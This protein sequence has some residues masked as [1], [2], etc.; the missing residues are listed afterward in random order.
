MA[1]VSLAPHL[2]AL[3]E[4][5]RQP[6]AIL[7]PDIKSILTEYVK[8]GG[9]LAEALNALFSGYCGVPHMID[10]VGCILQELGINC[11]DKIYGEIHDRLVDEL[12]R[13]GLEKLDEFMN[14]PEPPS[15]IKA[16]LESDVWV[17]FLVTLPDEL[18]LH[19]SPFLWFCLNR[20]AKEKPRKIRNLPAGCIQYNAYLP[21]LTSLIEDLKDRKRSVNDFIK[22]ISTDALTLSH[23]AFVCY[24][25]DDKR[26]IKAF[27][28]IDKLIADDSKRALF[29][30]MIL[31]LDGCDT[32]MRKVLVNNDPMTPALMEQLIGK[33][34]TSPF[35]K[36]LVTTKIKTDLFNEERR[37]GS[38]AVL[39]SSIRFLANLKDEKL[40]GDD[41]K[42]L[43]EAVNIVKSLRGTVRDQ[44]AAIV[45]GALRK[46]CFVD[47]WFPRGLQD[48][49]DPNLQRDWLV[50]KMMYETAYY[51]R[52]LAAAI[53][54]RALE[55]L[56]EA[57]KP[58]TLLDLLWYVM[59]RESDNDA[60]VQILEKFLDIDRE[61][62]ICN[63]HPAEI[64]SFFT[65]I[66]SEIL[67]PFSTEFIIVMVD[68]LNQMQSVLIP[69]DTSYRSNMAIR[70]IIHNVY[71]FCS[72]V[73]DHNDPLPEHTLSIL[74]D[75][76]D[77]SAL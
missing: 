31:A 67:P 6:D 39:R 66:L 56:P 45:M 54:E 59:R 57:P 9:D 14:Q 41:E 13:Q 23:A 50:I 72:A 53:F 25:M 73:K 44:L 38:D 11:R 49:K 21:V 40:E 22:L 65:N 47:A 24:T 29:R 77:K 30:S 18:K 34:K 4:T 17:D 5:L 33:A 63:R 48:L 68:C 3:L 16:L 62:Q 71:A 52:D 58:N 10:I 42:L 26:K 46:R 64:R 12:R 1:D 74:R 69:T 27:L 15:W 19:R 8:E 75:L 60:S 55:L 20:I 70:K 32:A 7:H 35:V 61:V 43:V 37:E 76:E 2:E 28:E 51:H 36:H